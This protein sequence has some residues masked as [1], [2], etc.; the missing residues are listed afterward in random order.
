[1]IQTAPLETRVQEYEAWFEKYPAVFQSEINAIRRMFELLP[2]NMTGIE[3]ALGTG[4]YSAALG[5][6][7]GVEP[8]EA[9]RLLALKRGI[10]VMN[11]R[12]ENLPY[13]A[14]HFDFVLF[15]TIYHLDNARA[16]LRE[17]N[18]VLKRNGSVI[19]AFIDKNGQIGRDYANRLD[20]D[21][22]RNATFYTPSEIAVLL[23]ETNFKDLSFVQ[24]LFHPLEETKEPEE[25]KDG[26]GEGSFVVVKATRKA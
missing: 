25:I 18:R 24:T 22:F 4:R 13:R 12:A 19:V 16:A 9:M 14:L 17:A 21:F 1:M 8:L 23:K 26:Y 7:E 2:E 15:V 11:A 10:E 20:S 5:I 6:K 3:V